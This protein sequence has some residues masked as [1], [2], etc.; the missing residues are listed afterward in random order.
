MLSSIARLCKNVILPP[1]PKYRKIALGPA[2]GCVMQVDFRTQSRT[3]F[4]LYE[5]EL[6]K[7]FRKLVRSGFS[8]F[9]VGGQGGYDALMLA[10]L[11]GGGQVISFECDADAAGVMRDTFARNSYPIE[12]IHAFVGKT[13]GE[14][15]TTLDAVADRAFTP[16][17]MKI[18]VEGAELDVLQGAGRILS[19]RKPSLILETHSKELETACSDLLH[20]HGY[21]PRIVDQRRWFRDHRIIEHNR[22]LVCEGRS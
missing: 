9:D 11:S 8:S 18:D 10:K 14:G 16:D 1:G 20:G 7:Y 17:F 6:H 19:T 2:A 12:T 15:T 21:A 22:W 4:G 3:Y 13:D 5:A